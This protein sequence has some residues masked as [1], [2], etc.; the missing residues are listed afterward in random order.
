MSPKKREGFSFHREVA[1]E[2]CIV[3]CI[4]DFSPNTEPLR[5]ADGCSPSAYAHAFRVPRK[6]YD[7]YR[8]RDGTAILSRIQI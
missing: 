8:K 1:H 6:I 4:C 3:R 2:I 7:A 5:R